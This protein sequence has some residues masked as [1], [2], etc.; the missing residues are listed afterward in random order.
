MTPEQL[1]QANK[2]SEQIATIDLALYKLKERELS[3][4]ERDTTMGGFT[5]P[6]VAGV[7]A[8]QCW[9]NDLITDDLRKIIQK[10]VI[11]ELTQKRNFLADQFADL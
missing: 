4:F 5:K 9:V 6:N 8:T 3:Q 10:S 7:P 11:E 2:L 1:T